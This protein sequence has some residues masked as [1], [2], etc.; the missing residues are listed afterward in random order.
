MEKRTDEERYEAIQLIL[1]KRTDGKD[2]SDIIFDMVTAD[3]EGT[4]SEDDHENENH[5]CTCSLESMGGVG[6]TVDYCYRWL[7]PDWDEED[8]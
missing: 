7:Y 1:R 8:D 5:T 2:W 3:C 4:F 6:G